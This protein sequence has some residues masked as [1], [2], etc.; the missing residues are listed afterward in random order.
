MEG[1]GDEASLKSEC[2]RA[3]KEFFEKAGFKGKLPSVRPMGGRGATFDAF[4]TAH[5]S[6]SDDT[7]IMLLVDSEEVPVD[8]QPWSH[9][10]S[11]DG[12]DRPSRATDDQ[13]QL[14]VVCMETWLM[15]DPDA[16][17][18]Y[19]GKNFKKTKL[20]VSDLENRAKSEI[21]S[22]IEAATTTA[23]PKGKYGKARDSFKLLAS[24]DPDKLKSLWW[25]DRFLAALKNHS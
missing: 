15:S 16:F 24:L 8:R 9:L 18:E 7:F 6:S 20:L 10:R 4:R 3:F 12:W 14:M 22:A 11:R 25:A 2:R 13:A 19:F 23:R 1:G 21:G 5:K 17:D